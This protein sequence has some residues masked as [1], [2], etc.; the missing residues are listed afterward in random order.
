MK[1]DKVMAL[2]DDELLAE[3][4]RLT[5]KFDDQI[6]DDPAHDI[7]AAFDLL[8]LAADRGWRYE[9]LSRDIWDEQKQVSMAKMPVVLIPPLPRPEGPIMVSRPNPSPEETA[10]AITKSFVLAMTGGK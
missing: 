8:R 6:I 10:R 1:P 4:R 5:G 9:I 3:V 2:S 7:A